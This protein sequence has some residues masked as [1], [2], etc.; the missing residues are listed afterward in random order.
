MV[1]VKLRVT[2]IRVGRVAPFRV[3][4]GRMVWYGMVRLRVICKRT[5]LHLGLRAM[6]RL[7]FTFRLPSRLE[8][9]LGLGSGLGRDLTLGLD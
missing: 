2:V 1:R 6:L 5:R 7:R 8:L 3:L 4:R 9:G